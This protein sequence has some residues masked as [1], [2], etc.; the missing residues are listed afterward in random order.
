MLVAQ[1]LH[2]LP[3]RVEGDQLWWLLYCKM[4]LLLLLRRC[5]RLV[6]LWAMLGLLS[7]CIATMHSKGGC[8]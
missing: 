7:V 3:A 8:I 4:L 2:D 5:A 1:L 6:W